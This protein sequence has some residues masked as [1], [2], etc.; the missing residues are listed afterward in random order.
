MADTKTPRL[1]PGLVFRGTYS[2]K[3][4]LV[5]ILR[6]IFSSELMEESF[7]YVPSP[8]TVREGMKDDEGGA[9]ETK[10]RIY[11]SFPQRIISYPCLI[12]K[13][14][15]FDASLTS[16]GES[17]EEGGNG[18]KDGVLVGST[19]TGYLTIPIEIAVYAKESTDDRDKLTD[20]LLQ[21]LRIV[22]RG[23]LDRSGVGYVKI[24]VEGEGQ[25]ADERDRV[26]IHTSSII[27]DCNTDFTFNMTV[28]ED[29]LVNK[30]LVRVFGETKPGGTPEVLAPGS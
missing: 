30:I 26:M 16:M 18:I 23:I 8:D 21:F 10:I 24:R 4:S 15:P 17:G 22:R 19:F 14:R 7:K 6:D 1:V 27:L 12:V 20:L 9:H 2:I 29:E 3:N 25:F 28:D 11:K 13:F 5:S